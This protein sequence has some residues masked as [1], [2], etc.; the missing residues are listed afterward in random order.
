MNKNGKWENRVEGILAGGNVWWGTGQKIIICMDSNLIS[1]C[2]ILHQKLFGVG[3]GTSQNKIICRDYNL[4]S[5][6]NI[7]HIKY[8][9]L[10]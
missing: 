2:N 8:T 7:L 10:L 4:I 3:C 5:R 9:L 6:C 1:R